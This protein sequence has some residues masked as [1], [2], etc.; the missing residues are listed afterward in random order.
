MPEDHEV[1][2][3]HANPRDPAD[4]FRR[5]PEPLRLEDTVPTKATES[6]HEPGTDPERDFMLR[7]SG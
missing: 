5:L 3:D 7:Y 2:K 4:R 6:V 1:H